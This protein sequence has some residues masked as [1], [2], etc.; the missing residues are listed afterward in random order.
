M[1]HRGQLYAFRLRGFGDP[2]APDVMFN[3]LDGQGTRLSDVL[4]NL[5]SQV[6]RREKVDGHKSSQVTLKFR[7]DV[8]LPGEHLNAAVFEHWR[9]GDRARVAKPSLQSPIPVNPEDG[10]GVRLA[11]VASTPP[12]GDVGYLV[13]HA[14][15]R[16]SLKPP[17][18]R[19]LKRLFRD[20]F[21]LYF[22]MHPLVSRSV[23]EQALDDGIGAMTLHRVGTASA[24][25]LFGSDALTWGNDP[26]ARVVTK[27]K[28]G[29]G[30]RFPKEALF[31]LV[32]SQRHQESKVTAEVFIEDQPKVVTFDED[33]MTF[34]R[35]FSADL[36]LPAATRA[37][38]VCEH[39]VGL[40][41]DAI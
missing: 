18:E 38:Q 37:V 31:A 26:D 2:L 12:S 39:L 1:A 19:E 23:I 10:V 22:E 28:P 11:V 4:P 8:D 33:E 14:H 25:D 9:F 30:N 41:P 36:R 32:Q 3:D 20:H 7:R 34:A 6:L 15:N 16:R 5:L 13:L 27:V 35:A 29:T 21:E 40:L 17:L 24:A